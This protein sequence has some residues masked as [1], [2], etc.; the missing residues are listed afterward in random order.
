DAQVLLKADGLPTYHLANVVDDHLMGISHVIRG[1][2]WLNSAPKHQLLYR[3]FDWEMPELCHMPLLRNPDKSKLSKRKNPTSINYY[4]AMGYLPEALLN[5]L[6]RM[7]W[8]MADGAE[9]FSFARMVECF[10]LDRVALGA[11]VFDAEKLDWLNGLWIREDLDEAAFAE[12][13]AEW[14]L[15]PGHLRRMVPLLKERV[16]KFTDIAA[17]A[18]PF[19]IGLPVIEAA[20]LDG[21]RL[22]RAAQVRVLQCAAWWLDAQGDW[23]RDALYAGLKNLAAGLEVRFKDFLQP[24]FV[25]MSGR[26]VCLPLFD[27]MEIL[28]AD[29]TRARVRHALAAAGGVSKK[30]GKVL[31]GEYRGLAE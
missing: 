11:P 8:A 10:D 4:R 9:K 24:L 25:A 14:A 6:A 21:L 31:E 5:Y 20:T 19:F 27:L 7:G 1:E 2:E 23:R 29:L 15:N 30:L 3:Y 16:E 18:E 13:V 12:R 28:G 17:L 22:E 26:A